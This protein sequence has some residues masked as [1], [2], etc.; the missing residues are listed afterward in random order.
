ME[1][2]QG[3]MQ[4]VAGA[5]GFGGFLT[6]H[7]NGT[8]RMRLDAS[9]NV[10]IGTTSPATKLEVM[11]GTNGYATINNTTD[12]NT[13]IKVMNTGRAYGIFVDGG[14]GASN[15]LRFYDFTAGSDRIKL[16]SSGNVGIGT[17]S[18][19]QKLHVN[20]NGIFD[21]YV[22]FK[23]STNANTYGFRGLSGIITADGGGQ[24]PTGWNFQY[25]GSS[26]SALY[27][28]SSGNVGIGTTSPSYL[29]DV[30]GVTRLGTLIMEASTGITATAGATTT[31][32]LGTDNYFAA[33]ASGTGTVTW[34]LSG[35]AASGLC[36]SFVLEY[37]NGGTVTNSWF[38][39]IKWP[40]GTA[41]TLTSS[42][43]DLLGFI[44][45]DGGTNWRG[46]LLQRASA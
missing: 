36:Q 45:D 40:A 29:L 44:T 34:A 5:S 41:P 19:S 9:G 42:G 43:V 7:T 24:W 13:G 23:D 3:Q 10:G 28:N 11:Y 1:L 20:G 17:T 4:L 8:E 16:D 33:T 18:P 26:N 35:V 39:G 2:S 22:I 30:N 25:G 6:I 31:L 46:V 21:G 32:A 14:S 38:S 12:S 37:T 27:I 15:G